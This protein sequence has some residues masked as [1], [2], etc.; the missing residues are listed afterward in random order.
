MKRL[1]FTFLPLYILTFFS[2]GNASQTGGENDS[3]AAEDSAEVEVEV[4]DHNFVSGVLTDEMMSCVSIKD[5][6]GVDHYYLKDDTFEGCDAVVGDSV[7][8]TLVDGEDG[9]Q[10]IRID[11]L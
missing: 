6:D 3:I 5:L 10:A 8:V 9:K 7:V 1:I 11:R 2:C 4:T